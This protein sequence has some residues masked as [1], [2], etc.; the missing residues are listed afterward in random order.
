MKKLARKG[1]LAKGTTSPCLGIVGNL[2][3]ITLASKELF[4]YQGGMLRAFGGLFESGRLFS[5]RRPTVYVSSGFSFEGENIFLESRAPPAVPQLLR[6]NLL[7][8]C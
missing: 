8:D 6:L 3:K 2:S 4:G 5:R 1:K 7:A